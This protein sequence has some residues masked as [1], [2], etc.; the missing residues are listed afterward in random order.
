MWERLSRPTHYPMI[1]FWSTSSIFVCFDHKIVICS[2]IFIS[3]NPFMSFSQ[4]STVAHQVCCSLLLASFYIALLPKNQWST[5]QCPPVEM[6]FGTKKC[7]GQKNFKFTFTI[8]LLTIDPTL[9]PTVR[10]TSTRRPSP[11]VLLRPL[12]TGSYQAGRTTYQCK[13]CPRTRF[14]SPL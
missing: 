5:Q 14:R 1:Y 13:R 2:S 4:K 7:L 12:S 9:A 3:L 6:L 11:R 8:A 10:F